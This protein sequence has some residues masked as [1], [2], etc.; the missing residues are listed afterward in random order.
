MQGA[1][2]S[3]LI[4]W[5]YDS[6]LSSQQVFSLV[7]LVKKKVLPQN[8]VLAFLHIWWIHGAYFNQLFPKGKELREG[9]FFKSSLIALLRKNFFSFLTAILDTTS[10]TR[11]LSPLASINFELCH[12]D[13]LL[14]CSKRN[15]SVCKIQNRTQSENLSIIYSATWVI[16]KTI[17]SS[18]VKIC[19]EIDIEKWR[20]LFLVCNKKIMIIMK[21]D[22]REPW[23]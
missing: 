6:L 14:F 9:S 8:A 17:W 3:S 22:R 10:V 18:K 19:E 5:S 2:S 15:E 16:E 7:I 13:L 20:A 11:A 12:V 4:C 1:C 23:L 21:I